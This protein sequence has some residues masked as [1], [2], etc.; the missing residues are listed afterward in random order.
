MRSG[1]QEGEVTKQEWEA[2][3]ESADQHRIHAERTLHE[4]AK[5]YAGALDHVREVIALAHQIQE[6]AAEREGMG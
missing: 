6:P 2:M 4:A 1:G 5:K 3:A